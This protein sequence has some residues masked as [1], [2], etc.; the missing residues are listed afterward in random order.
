MLSM[1]ISPEKKSALDKFIQANLSYRRRSHTNGVIQVA[2][3]L[4]LKWGADVDKAK[5]AALC[6]DIMRS[7]GEKNNLTHGPEAAELIER[8]FGICDKEILDAV[9][10]HTTGRETMTLLDKIVYLADAIEP[11]RD[12]TG[13]EK[14]RDMAFIDLEKACLISFINTKAYITSHNLY[15]DPNT[16]KAI[17]GLNKQ[18]ESRE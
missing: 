10:C 13:V 3:Q 18:I 7:K 5:V 17:E 1:Y 8:E 12:Y 15:L 9:R 2:E 14:I 16:D 6:H 11:N 4:A